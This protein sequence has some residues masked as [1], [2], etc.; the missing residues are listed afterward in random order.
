ML[1]ILLAL[2]FIALILLVAVIGQPNEFT[3]LR[4]IRIRAFAEQIFPHV[5]ELRKWEPWNPW[6]KLDPNCQMTYD[7]P[8]AG[9]GARYSWSGNNKVGAGCNTITESRSNELVR[10]RLEF[11][12]PMAATNTA[13]FRFRSDGEGTIVTWAMSG[14]R[15][16]SGKLF[17]LLLNCDKMCADQFDKGLASIKS[18]VETKSSDL[19]MR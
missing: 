17:G 18:L 19:A 7:G 14:K 15:S 1:P 10:L 5:N 4:Q 9:V 6:G 13:E 3:V 16:F 11:I 8:P 12:K 2:A